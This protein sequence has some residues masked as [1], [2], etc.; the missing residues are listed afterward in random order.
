MAF[1]NADLEEE[2]QCVAP[3]GY[4]S[5]KGRCR[6]LLKAWN[7]ASSTNMVP[8]NIKMVR[9][10]IEQNTSHL[11]AYYLLFLLPS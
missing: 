5:S 6:K 7:K 2:D 1:V 9:A 11:L 4:P 3:K 10:R 8:Q